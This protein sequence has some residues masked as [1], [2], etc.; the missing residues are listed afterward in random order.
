[1]IAV[2]RPVNCWLNES[3]SLHHLARFD[4][5]GMAGV[6]QSSP[7][8]N[9]QNVGKDEIK[10]QG[11]GPEALSWFFSSLL[12]GFTAAIATIR[13]DPAPVQKGLTAFLGKMAIWFQLDRSNKKKRAQMARLSVFVVLDVSARFKLSR[14]FPLRDSYPGLALVYRRHHHRL[15]HRAFHLLESAQI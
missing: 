10:Q 1:M 11:N 12:I 15:Y 2:F 6:Y 5:N 9:K 13:H 3:N 14:L 4:C 8:T 7:A